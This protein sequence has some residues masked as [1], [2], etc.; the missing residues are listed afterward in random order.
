MAVNA[1]REQDHFCQVSSRANSSGRQTRSEV[2]FQFPGQTA[3]SRPLE[4]MVDRFVGH[5]PPIATA[6]TARMLYREQSPE[7]T[8]PGN[9]TTRPWIGFGLRG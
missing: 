9:H 8:L 7:S 5:M 2:G 4:G 6:V 1:D 3:V